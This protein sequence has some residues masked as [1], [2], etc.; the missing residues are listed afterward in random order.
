MNLCGL[1]LELGDDN[2]CGAKSGTFAGVL[3]GSQKAN[4]F[5][6]RKTWNCRALR[7]IVECYDLEGVVVDLRISTLGVNLLWYEVRCNQS[8]VDE[9]KIK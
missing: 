2:L 7:K 1:L 5:E 8:L 6:C 9:V 3:I 4:P